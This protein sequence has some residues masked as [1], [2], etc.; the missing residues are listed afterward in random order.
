MFSCVEHLAQ[1]L[2]HNCATLLSSLW[3]CWLSLVTCLINRKKTGNHYTRLSIGHSISILVSIYPGSS[4]L[5][6]LCFTYGKPI[7]YIQVFKADIW[8]LSEYQRIICLFFQRF[9]VDILLKS[10]SFSAFKM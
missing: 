9:D 8:G 4:C 10:S 2:A 3:R 6:T 7:L 1:C 5:K